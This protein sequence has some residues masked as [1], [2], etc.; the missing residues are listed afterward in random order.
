MGKLENAYHLERAAGP[1]MDETFEQ[2]FKE[3]SMRRCSNS[4]PFYS[5]L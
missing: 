3:K 2:F 5:Q 1:D 4:Y